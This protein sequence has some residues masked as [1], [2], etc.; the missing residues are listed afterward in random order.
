MAGNPRM[1]SRQKPL[2]HPISAIQR[3]VF[4]R[5]EVI[6]EICWHDWLPLCRIAPHTELQEAD[7]RPLARRERCVSSGHRRSMR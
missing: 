6:Y 2:S 5:S 7:E 3:R 4:H 1:A